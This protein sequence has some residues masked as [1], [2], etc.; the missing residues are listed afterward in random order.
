MQ[1]LLR[2]VTD[3]RDM[4]KRKLQDQQLQLA[5]KI[6]SP[7]QAVIALIL[8]QPTSLEHFQSLEQK[9]ALLDIAIAMSAGSALTKIIMFVERTLRGHVLYRHLA[10]RP[11]AAK[12][13]N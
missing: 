2:G 12:V 7:R 6:V 8:G 3:E 10:A 1:E 9:L 13:W 5:S 11:M 4:L